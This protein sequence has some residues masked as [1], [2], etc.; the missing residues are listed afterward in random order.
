MFSMK[1]FER[2]IDRGERER[3]NRLE[4]CSDSSETSV[5]FRAWGCFHFFHPILLAGALRVCVAKRKR[6]RS[7]SKFLSMFLF[8]L[9]LRSVHDS[10]VGLENQDRMCISARV[11][12]HLEVTAE[13]AYTQSSY[14]RVFLCHF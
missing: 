11:A 13:I 10:A 5:F 8:V 9:F 3:E 14:S 12:I 7:K 1:L 2:K 4:S 6:R